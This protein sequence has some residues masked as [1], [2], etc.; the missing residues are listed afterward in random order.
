MSTTEAEA[1]LEDLVQRQWLEYRGKYGC[2]IL[3]PRTL[4]EL[5]FS[6][7]QGYPDER[8][9]CFICQSMVTE[10]L[11]CSKVFMRTKESVVQ[12]GMEKEMAP[13]D[14]EGEERGE[15]SEEEE[16]AVPC[17]GFMHTYCAKTYLARHD[18]CKVCSN[19]FE[20]LPVGMEVLAHQRP[21]NSS[22][23]S[24]DKRPPSTRLSTTQVSS[25]SDD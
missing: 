18:R 6:F 15:G 1:L 16:E 13:P 22:I 19:L 12:E 24:R 25:D 2:Y 21:Q 11:R 23:P 8:R 5:K 10:G 4:L 3:G 14:A 17:E 7:A 9:E 20:G